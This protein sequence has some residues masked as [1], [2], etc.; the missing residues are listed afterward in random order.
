VELHELG[1]GFQSLR[2]LERKKA[3]HE[4]MREREKERKSERELVT[5]DNDKQH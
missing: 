3:R 5:L 2:E 1:L 4:T